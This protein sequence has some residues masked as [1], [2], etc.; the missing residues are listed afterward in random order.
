MDSIVQRDD[1]QAFV[2]GGYGRNLSMLKI[3]ERVTHI[4]FERRT[5]TLNGPYVIDLLIYKLIW[6]LKASISQDQQW[7]SLC[8]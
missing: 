4:L 1:P 3:H 6:C 8:T 2:I 5:L 7:K